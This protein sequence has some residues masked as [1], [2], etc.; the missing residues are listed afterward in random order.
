[1]IKVPVRYNLWHRRTNSPCFT[2]QVFTLTLILYWKSQK[3]LYTFYVNW[4]TFL[5]KIFSQSD[6]DAMVHGKNVVI[7]SEVQGLNPSNISTHFVLRQRLHCLR[8]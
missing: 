8:Q 5:N 7:L 6:I 3:N 4:G 2:I 1:M